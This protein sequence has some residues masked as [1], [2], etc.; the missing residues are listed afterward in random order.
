MFHVLVGIIVHQILVS[1]DSRA[2]L[3]SENITL[4]RVRSRKESSTR[5]N[6]HVSYD[7]VKLGP[8]YPRSSLSPMTSAVITLALGCLAFK[9]A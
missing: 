3:S 2:I 6:S 7:D 9:S 1:N 4:S 5:S 8:L